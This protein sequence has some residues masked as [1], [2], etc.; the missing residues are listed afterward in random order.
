MRDAHSAVRSSDYAAVALPFE[1]TH[2]SDNVLFLLPPTSGRTDGPATQ[3]PVHLFWLAVQSREGTLMAGDTPPRSW[4][5]VGFNFP[6]AHGVGPDCHLRARCASC[7]RLV[8]F[9]PT[10][11]IEQQLGGLSLAYFAHRLRCICGARQGILEIWT[12]PAPDSPRDRSIY[13]FR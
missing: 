4:G 5:L 3:R 10:P 13:A 1:M 6:L 7:G 12:G 2:H 8:M 11:W 9:D